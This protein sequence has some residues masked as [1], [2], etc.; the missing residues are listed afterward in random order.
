[1]SDF[2]GKKEMH[3]SHQGHSFAILQAPTS[4]IKRLQL[5]KNVLYWVAT[6][7]VIYTYIYMYTISNIYYKDTRMH[8]NTGEM[9]YYSW[10]FGHF[11]WHFKKKKAKINRLPDTQHVILKQLTRVVNVC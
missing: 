4:N 3:I 10:L 7:E 8:V 9:V 11:T 5:V 2:K 1:M 6:G